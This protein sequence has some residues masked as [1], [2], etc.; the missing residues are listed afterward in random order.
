MNNDTSIESLPAVQAVTAEVGALETFAATY[1]VETAEQYQHGADDL[2]RVKAAQK[3]LEETRTGL[4]KPIN[5]SLRRLNDFFRAPADRLAA[6]E[7][8]IKA[9]LTRFADEQERIRREEQR[10]LEEAARKERERL[11]AQAR[12]AERKA[13]EKAEA[14]RRA[15]EEARQAAE[16][17][18]AEGR[19]EE[20]RKAAAAA[21]AADARAAATEAKAASKVEAI[22]TRAAAVVA[23]VVVR[24]PPKVAGVATREVWKFRVVN[25]AL[26]PDQYKVIDEARIRKVVQALKT[27]ANIP[28]VEVYAERQIAAGAA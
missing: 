1:A 22:E 14:E 4:T 6:I 2:K 24:E 16:K 19:A 27:D 26:V 11:E 9:A 10:K 12:E 21:A 7:R 15:A 25:P 23:P 8:T 17:A 18:A 3:R 20:A 28:G 13:R 5:E